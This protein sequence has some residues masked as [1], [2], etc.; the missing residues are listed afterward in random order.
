MEFYMSDIPMKL[1]KKE[2][3]RLNL[4]CPDCNKGLVLISTVK[5]EDQSLEIDGGV[6][7]ETESC[8]KDIRQYLGR[9]AKKDESY[10]MK[11]SFGDF[12]IK[13]NSANKFAYN[14]A[15]NLLK[16]KIAELIE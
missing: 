4:T 11:K 5:R 3:T 13:I 10:L 6:Y 15:L 7:C 1:E 2:K 14:Y 8:K 12:D 16:R 9:F